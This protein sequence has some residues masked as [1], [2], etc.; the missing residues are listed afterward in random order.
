MNK[1]IYIASKTKHAAKWQ[2]LRAKGYNIISTWIDEAGEGESADM[3]GLCNRCVQESKDCDAMVVYR[4]EDDY[5]KGAFIEM[6]I[7]LSVPM[8]PIFLV[9]P[10]LPYGSAFTFSHQVLSART[11]EEALEFINYPYRLR[12]NLT[13]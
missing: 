10:V 8:K 2:A 9:G 6:G 11:V 13:D 12:T 7:A 3:V 4:E 5:L 1:S